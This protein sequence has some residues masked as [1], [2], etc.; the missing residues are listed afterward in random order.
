MPPLG[1]YFLK[2][3]ENPFSNFNLKIL[4]NNFSIHYES[5]LH[6]IL[7]LTIINCLFHSK[8]LLRLL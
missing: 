7:P 2:N 5:A 1:A 8:V 3:V 6:S 4:K